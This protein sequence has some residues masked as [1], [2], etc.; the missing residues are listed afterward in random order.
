MCYPHKILRV[1]F[2]SLIR[3]T[4]GIISLVDWLRVMYS[5]SVVDN[6]ISVCNLKRHTTGQL[7]MRIC[8][9]PTTWKI[10]IYKPFNPFY[11]IRSKFDASVSCTWQTFSY[12]HYSSFRSNPGVYENLTH[13]W[14]AIAIPGLNKSCRQFNIPIADL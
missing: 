11:F 5:A 7:W 9:V 6:V 3:L 10:S 13:W 12:F 4:W 1:E 14:T 8:I 2:S